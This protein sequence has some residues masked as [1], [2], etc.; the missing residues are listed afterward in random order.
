V[1]S[2]RV[3]GGEEN[4]LDSLIEDLD[5][6]KQSGVL[7][8]ILKVDELYAGKYLDKA[9]GQIL[10]E[11]RDGLVIDTTRFN[12]GRLIGKSLVK[13]KGAHRLEGMLALYGGGIEKIE[14]S[15]VVYDVVPT[16]L[17]LFKLPVPN[18]VDG[19]SAVAKGIGSSWK[20]DIAE[21]S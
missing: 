4:F 12:R 21:S 1:S 7:K 8:R 16:V 6:L 2:L 10:I 11:A 9:P 20:L 19:V 17:D 18:Y 15:P 3:P 13:K 5:S 14:P